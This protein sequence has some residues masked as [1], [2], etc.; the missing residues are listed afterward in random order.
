MNLA[1]LGHQAL[2]GLGKAVAVEAEAPQTLRGTVDGMQGAGRAG[3]LQG[4]HLGMGHVPPPLVVADPPPKH[5]GLADRQ[6]AG[7]P[8][9]PLEPHQRQG[10]A[11]LVDE[12]GFE[13]APPLLLDLLDFADG[14]PQLHLNGPS[15]GFRDPVETGP[16][17]I[18]E[19]QMKQQVSA[20]ANAQIFRQRFRPFGTDSLE[21][22]DR[23]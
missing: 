18:A 16:V 23:G 8:L 19:R 17:L 9:D 1:Q 2:N 20:G 4:E 5:T 3:F 6:V 15:H 13:P 21:E 10:I 11:V 22:F 7:H 12:L 14:A